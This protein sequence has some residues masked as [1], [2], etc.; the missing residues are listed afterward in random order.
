MRQVST[1]KNAK[2]TN[3]RH[4]LPVRSLRSLR[5]IAAARERAGGMI[6]NLCYPY[7]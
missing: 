2:S 6:L 4:E 5:L 3:A 7:E 1:A